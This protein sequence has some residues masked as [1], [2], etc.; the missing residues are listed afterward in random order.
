MLKKKIAIKSP[1][2][3]VCTLDDEKV[4]LGCYRQV[5]E[6]RNWFMY[7]DEQKSEVLEK[8]HARRKV[9]DENNYNRYV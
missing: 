2:I 7:T 4:C 9:K 5:E 1:C 6:V 8:A 3:Q